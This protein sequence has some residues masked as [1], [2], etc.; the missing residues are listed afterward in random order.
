MLMGD[1]FIQINLFT[2]G[3]KNQYMLTNFDAKKGT[4]CM[5]NIEGIKF[6]YSL[7]KHSI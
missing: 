4:L 2:I 7:T 5:C 1:L 6:H 3:Y